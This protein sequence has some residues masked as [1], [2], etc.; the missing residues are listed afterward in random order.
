MATPGDQ[1]AIL[2]RDYVDEALIQFRALVPQSFSGR[3][4][5]EVTSGDP[6]EAIVRVA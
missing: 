4:T 6:A 5:A 1:E 2:R 3:W